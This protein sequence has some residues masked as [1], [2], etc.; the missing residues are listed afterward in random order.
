VRNTPE[1]LRDIREAILRIRK[2]TAQ[3]RQVF[4]QDELVQTWV[5][6]HLEIIGEAV[7]SIPQDFKDLHPEISWKQISRMRN[8]LIHIYFGI[9]R[10]IV[11]EVVE[12]DLPRLKTSID[13]ILDKEE[14]T[15]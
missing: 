14:D 4:D 15:Q 12:R 13:A 5:V 6:H 3:G 11:W 8:I 1:R 7:R 9:D 2:Y 10:D